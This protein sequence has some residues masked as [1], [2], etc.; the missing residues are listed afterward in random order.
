MPTNGLVLRSV[1]IFVGG[2]WPG[3]TVTSSPSGNIFLLI[4]F[5]SRSRGGESVSPQASGS[6]ARDNE[7]KENEGKQE[8]LLFWRRLCSLRRLLLEHRQEEVA[9]PGHSAREEKRVPLELL[10]FSARASFRARAV[11][12]LI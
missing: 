1:P 6:D 8:G 11:N 9:T 2:P 3:S 5:M 7:Q 4:P 12:V 10:N